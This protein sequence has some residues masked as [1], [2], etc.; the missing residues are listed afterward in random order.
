MHEISKNCFRQN[1]KMTKIT[2]NKK[3]ENLLTLLDDDKAV[4]P[5]DL[6]A[7]VGLQKGL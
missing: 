7:F 2:K 3:T 5:H 6:S 4:Q 1:I